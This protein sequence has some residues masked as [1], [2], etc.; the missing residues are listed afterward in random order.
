MKPFS[1]FKSPIY[2]DVPFR[3]IFW[4]LERPGPLS[5][6]SLRAAPNASELAQLIV[7]CVA[8]PDGG[9]PQ[10]FFLEAHEQAGG[11]SVRINTSSATPHFRLQLAAL[12]WR[13]LRLVLY[14]ANARGRGDVTVLDDIA[15]GDAEMRTGTVNLNTIHNKTVS[16][17]KDQ[18][19]ME[20][21]R[22]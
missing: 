19:S 2:R 9:L 11:G 18:A 10:R 16:D 8:G 13:T 14:A 21:A 17:A 6:C 5:N 20:N 15:L 12:G 4:F 1:C 7:E 3:F 22:T